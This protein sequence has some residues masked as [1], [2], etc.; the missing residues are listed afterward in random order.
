MTMP[1]KRKAAL[2]APPLKSLKRARQVTSAFH[3]AEHGRGTGPSPDRAAYQDASQRATARH[4]TTSRFVFSSLTALN[5]RPA[6]GCPRPAV[7]EIGAVNTQLLA[8]P[9][10][11][12]RAIDVR[13]AARGVEAVDFFDLPLPP[14]AQGEG[15]AE[16]HFDVI[17]C[18]MV[19][20]CVAT[21]E[22]RWQMLVRM[23][24]HLKSPGG[25]AILALPRRCVERGGGRGAAP[26]GASTSSAAAPSDAACAALWAPFEGVM[27]AAGLGPVLI[28]KASPKIAFWAVGVKD[29]EGGAAEK[30]AEAAEKAAERAVLV[31]GAGFEVAAPV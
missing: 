23:R 15:G 14:P 8:C 5:R 26:G 25:V 6:A 13:A 21:P 3:A 2:V 7:L 31:V 20:N 28:R 12:V 16:S 9:W 10:L 19:L 18:A 24:A 27:A 1:P 22:L 17:V 30:A 4:K 29:V 11:A